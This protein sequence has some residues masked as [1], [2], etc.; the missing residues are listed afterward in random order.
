[1]GAKEAWRKK[2]PWLDARFRMRDVGAAWGVGCRVC[3]EVQ[4]ASPEK[5][6]GLMKHRHQAEKGPET[7]KKA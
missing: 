3:S 7:K 4:N 5:F 6:A 2:H 1:M